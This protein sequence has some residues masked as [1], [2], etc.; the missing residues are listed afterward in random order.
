MWAERSNV[1]CKNSYRTSV[2]VSYG[3]HVYHSKA[4][5]DP[6]LE[7]QSWCKRQTEKDGFP[8]EELQTHN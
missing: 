3:R 7:L 6:N 5:E 1:M 4:P 8:A 2:E